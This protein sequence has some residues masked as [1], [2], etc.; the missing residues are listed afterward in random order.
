MQSR[1]SGQSGSLM[2]EL[3][4]GISILTVGVLGFMA[5]Y[6]S[7]YRAIATVDE[8]DQVHVAFE[9]LAET[10]AGQVVGDVYANFE[11]TTWEIG[12]LN[13]PDG[14]PATVLV[15]CH[16]DENTIPDEFGGLAD[17]DGNPGS[18][19][20]DASGSYKILPVQLSVTFASSV[21]DQTRDFFVLLGEDD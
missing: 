2:I 12:N 6:F 16:V 9:N 8:L 10:L 3:L 5:S 7:S 15:T 13:D 4:V 11:G 1:S 19:T 14:N 18:H 20:S 21:G 17:I